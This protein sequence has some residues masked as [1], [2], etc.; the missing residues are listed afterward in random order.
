MEELLN[1]Y[2]LCLIFVS[3]VGGQINIVSVFSLTFDVLGEFPRLECEESYV[4]I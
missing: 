2:M 4:R 1:A 3:L